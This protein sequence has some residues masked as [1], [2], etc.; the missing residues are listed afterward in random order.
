MR[1]Q[2]NKDVNGTMDDHLSRLEAKV[3]EAIDIIQ[4]LRRENGEL[5]SRCEELGNRLQDAQSARERLQS[6][7]DAAQESAVQIEFFEQ[8]RQLLEERVGGLLEKLEAMG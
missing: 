3:L 6:Q 4:G 2:P 7:L 1:G 8:R 5:R